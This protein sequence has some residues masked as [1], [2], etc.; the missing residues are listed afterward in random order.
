MRHRSVAANLRHIFKGIPPGGWIKLICFSDQ[1]CNPRQIDGLEGSEGDRHI[2][3][4]QKIIHV[5]RRLAHR[6]ARSVGR[7]LFAT[8]RVIGGEG[9]RLEIASVRQA[10]DV[11]ASVGGQFGN[12]HHGEALPDARALGGI[13]ID[14]DHAVDSDVQLLGNSPQVDRFVFPVGNKG[15]DIGQL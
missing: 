9:D 6:L 13:I 4:A 11:L 15:R 1:L 3:P 14:K 12:G 7:V 5:L 2:E 10:A 8:P